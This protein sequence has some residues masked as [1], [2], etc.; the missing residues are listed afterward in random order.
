[1]IG[2]KFV[3]KLSAISLSNNTVHRRIDDMSADI[4]DQVFQEIKSAPLPIF[5]IQLK[6]STDFAN[7]SQFLVYVGYINDGDFKDEFLFCKPFEMITT[8]HDV[9]DTVVSF[10]KEHEISWEKVVVFAQMVLQLC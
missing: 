6:E 10:L 1:M 3:T 2:D 4:L 5:S 7:C 8:V 9:F